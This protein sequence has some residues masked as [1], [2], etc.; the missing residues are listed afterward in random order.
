MNAEKVI[1]V[2]TE[3]H[4]NKDLELVSKTDKAGTIRYANE[5]FVNVSGYEEYELVGQGHNII[6]H[7]DMP[8]VIFKLLWSNLLKGKDFHAVVKNMAKNGRYYW[9]ITRF[10]IFKN[11]KGEITGYMGRRKSVQPEVAERVEELYKKLV[12][13]EEASGIEAA[14]DYLTG[15]LEDQKKTYEEYLS[16]ILESAKSMPEEDKN[17]SKKS[18]FRRLF[19]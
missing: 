18:I 8:K 19:G 10:E 13:I 14:E 11:D 15:Y 7:P 2:N 1:P 17:T 3:V 16:D 12:Q 6:R 5:A 9:V 4:W